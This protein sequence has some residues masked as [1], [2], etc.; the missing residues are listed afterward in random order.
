MIF[1]IKSCGIF[2]FLDTMDDILSGLTVKRPKVRVIDKLLELGL[3]SDRK[4]LH[5]KGRKSMS[6][7]LR[8]G[9]LFYFCWIISV[10]LRF[11]FFSLFVV[12]IYYFT[13]FM[14]MFY[15]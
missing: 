7:N 9:K 6:G 1:C 15:R 5:K 13:I 2:I 11:S 10:I 3:I 14:M 12:F 8:G 4:E